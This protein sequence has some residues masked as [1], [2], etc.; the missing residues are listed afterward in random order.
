MNATSS[1]NLRS[2]STNNPTPASPIQAAVLSSLQPGAR[3]AMQALPSWLQPV[4]TEIT[5]KALPNEKPWFPWT[6]GGRFAAVLAEWATGVGAGITFASL[7]GIGY[8]LLPVTALM[9][10]AASRALQTGPGVHHAAHDNL[11]PSQQANNLAG[12][13]ASILAWVSPLEL[14]REDH[15]VHHNRPAAQDDE[16][17]RFLIDIAGLQPGLPVEEYWRRFWRTLVSPRFHGRYLA[18]RFR[19]QLINAPMKHRVAAWAWVIAVALLLLVASNPLAILLGYLIPVLLLQQMA[20]WVGMLGLH[21]WTRVDDGTRTRREM[22]AALTHARFFGE[23]TPSDEL[24]GLRRWTAWTGWGLRLATWHLAIRMAFVQADLPS[25]D[26]HHDW[27]A[28]DWANHAYARRDA[29]ASGQRSTPLYTEVWGLR[30][31]IQATFESLAALPPETV[32]GAPRTQA[33]PDRSF[34]GM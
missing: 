26:Y 29:I 22:T 1:T 3:E 18:A 23:P 8:A 30:A 20:A 27:P 5:G 19:S 16:D 2:D 33:D 32:L 17:L 24:R 10:V 6:R 14:Y 34:G 15:K 9:T 31:A 11:F 25:H 7:G 28:G 21:T 4:I 13:L 12:G